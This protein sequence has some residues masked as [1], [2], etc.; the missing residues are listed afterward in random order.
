MPIQLHKHARLHPDLFDVLAYI[1]YAKAPITRT[2]R[3]RANK[4]LIL[5]GHDNKLQTFIEFVLGQY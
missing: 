5:D 2:E 3:V 4:A 1:T